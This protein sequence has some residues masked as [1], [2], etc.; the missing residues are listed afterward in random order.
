LQ[1]TTLPIK[2]RNYLAWLRQ[3]GLAAALLPLCLAVTAAA[4]WLGGCSGEYD[5]T[6]LSLSLLLYPVFLLVTA[7][8]GWWAFTRGAVVG[9]IS[10]EL[11]ALC[12]LAGGLGLLALPPGMPVFDSLHTLKIGAPAGRTIEIQ[13]VR[14]AEGGAVGPSRFEFTGG[15]ETGGA[16]F[17]SSSADPGEAVLSIKQRGGL[18]IVFR[19]DARSGTAG[20]TWDGERQEIDLNSPEDT[21]RTIELPGFTRGSLSLLQG[22]MTLLLLAA[23]WASFSAA[24]LALVWIAGREDAGRGSHLPY[25]AVAALVILATVSAFA[26]ATVRSYGDTADYMGTGLLVIGGEML[27]CRRPFLV[28]L[29]YSLLGKNAALI[30]NFQ[31]FLSVLSWCF[32]AFTAAGSMR[33]KRVGLAAFVFVMLF[34]ASCLVAQWQKILLSDSI[35]LSTFA[36]LVGAWIVFL[37]KRNWPAAAGV[38]A[39]GL[40]WNFTRYTNNYFILMAVLGLA[41]G[42]GMSRKMRTRQFA[43]ILAGYALIFA[44]GQAEI[45]RNGATTVPFGNI[46][47]TRI[48]P[49]AEA[50]EFFTR[51]GMPPLPAG[52]PVTSSKTAWDNGWAY[53][54]QPGM[55]EFRSWA[56]SRG[57][58]VYAAYLLAHPQALLGAPWNAREKLIGGWSFPG[59]YTP[60]G[61]RA[62]LGLWLNAASFPHSAGDVILLLGFTLAVFAWRLTRKMPVDSL[63][64]LAVFLAV[65]A[66]P[67]ILVSFFGDPYDLE[68]HALAGN[69]QL[70]LGVWLALFYSIDRFN[71]KTGA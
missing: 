47:L 57:Q 61:Y 22:L 43:L 55:E 15:W 40:A 41:A 6:R 13:S 66:V 32:L 34:G 19:S 18:R 67:L 4:F 20:V 50:R 68:R 58:A 8:A 59:Y 51:A 14:T 25:L 71:L 54:T 42:M 65:T 45:A 3:N 31:L 37:Q 36:L 26:G 2:I 17:L 5:F 69:L 38:I 11:L 63:W 21:T 30:T 33:K 39:A 12:A 60:E 49:D 27:C 52:T 29:A 28:P 10:R 7:G 46:L 23:Y 56:A 35:A 53:L 9:K 64:G 70:R 16:G 62:P 44:A 24:A 1:R 48:L